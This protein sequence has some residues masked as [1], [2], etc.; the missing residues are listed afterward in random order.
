M[1]NLTNVGILYQPD[2]E[3]SLYEL[4][5]KLKKRIGVLEGI[6][7]GAP[8]EQ[9]EQGEIGPRGFGLH[10]SLVSGQTGVVKLEEVDNSSTVQAGDLL[11]D[12]IGYV[13]TITEIVVTE[14]QGVLVYLSDALTRIVGAKGEQ[15]VPGF[16]SYV[17]GDG[18]IIEGEPTEENPSGTIK[19]NTKRVVTFTTLNSHVTRTYS[20]EPTDCLLELI[21]TGGINSTAIVKRF[22]LRTGQ[23]ADRII[24]NNSADARAASL[25]WLDAYSL[26][27]SNGN[28]SF[29]RE[30]KNIMKPE[31]YDGYSEFIVPRD[32]VIDGTAASN[33]NPTYLK[34]NQILVISALYSTSGG[35]AALDKYA[36]TQLNLRMKVKWVADT[37]GG[38]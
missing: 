30:L 37:E 23:S 2:N 25:L 16:S 3:S 34:E 31:Y 27:E 6:K 15:G 20:F 22:V 11:F 35:D 29:T 26:T 12:V 18:I 9:G 7:Q 5:L 4:Y 33:F 24:I 36:K 28:L 32:A 13:Y 38:E 17:A 10:Y 8:G 14:T 1:N 19:I 21:P